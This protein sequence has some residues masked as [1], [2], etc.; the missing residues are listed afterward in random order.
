MQSYENSEQFGETMSLPNLQNLRQPFLQNAQAAQIVAILSPS[1]SQCSNG[2]ALL[3]DIF[4]QT[5]T[6]KLQGYII[7]AP[8]RS[9]DTPQLA[10]A[11]GERLSDARLRH[12]WDTFNELG[13][14]FS[15]P[16]E[17]PEPAH[18][19]LYLIFGPCTTWQEDQAPQ[20]AYWMHQFPGGNQSYYLHPERFNRAIQS[21]LVRSGQ[22]E[23][24]AHL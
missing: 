19:N 2:V 13:R 11:Q 7:W 22:V 1:S 20:P 18:S 17:L 24:C 10:Y 8:M 14:F 5:F 12:Y 21:E 6:D 23:D 15:S 9:K 4:A 3:R 16:L